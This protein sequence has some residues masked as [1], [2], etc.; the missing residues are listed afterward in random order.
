MS[1][2]FQ[3]NHCILPKFWNLP[4]FYYSYNTERQE[5]HLL[6]IWYKRNLSKL[7]YN[8]SNQ[9]LLLIKCDVSKYGTNNWELD[10][11]ISE[12]LFFSMS[13]VNFTRWAHIIIN[14]Y[15]HTH[16]FR[17]FLLTSISFSIKGSSNNW[18]LK[19][20]FLRAVPHSGHIPEPFTNNASTQ[21]SHLQRKSQLSWIDKVP[22]ISKCNVTDRHTVL[23]QIR[24]W[25]QDNLYE[26]CHHP[27][28]NYIIALL[29]LFFLHLKH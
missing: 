9:I 14:I 3:C 18:T 15:T 23:L 27:Q 25:R 11:D 6:Y 16:S 29:L 17:I 7:L 10:L 8:E 5:Q 12:Y 4:L 22:H 19:L 13:V 26:K 21:V 1:L 2:S 24:C 28:N 20:F